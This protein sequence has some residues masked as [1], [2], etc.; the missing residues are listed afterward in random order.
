MTDGTVALDVY[1][2]VG[3]SLGWLTLTLDKE[4]SWGSM[5]R[6]SQSFTDGVWREW[7]IFAILYLGATINNGGIR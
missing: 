1:E 4:W 7:V 6:D 2:K 5:R 3:F